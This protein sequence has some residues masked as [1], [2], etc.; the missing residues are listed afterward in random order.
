MSSPLIESKILV[1]SSIYGAIVFVFGKSAQLRRTLV[2]LTFSFGHGWK[3]NSYP[4][5]FG[6]GSTFIYSKYH[7]HSLNLFVLS[8][9]KSVPM[10]LT[11]TTSLVHLFFHS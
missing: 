7:I 8:M 2:L 4:I 5:H 1:Y 9:G 11:L 10:P 3:R 6:P